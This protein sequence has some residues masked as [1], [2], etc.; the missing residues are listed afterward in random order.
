M[1]FLIVEDHP[2]TA[3]GLKMIIEEDFDNP[4][5]DIAH[6]GKE[7]LSLLKNNTYTVIV[8]DITLPDTDTQ[9]L[10]SNIK[11]ISEN[12]EIL[13]CSNSEPKLYAMSYISM[14]ASGYIHKSFSTQQLVTAIK[15]V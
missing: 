3:M 14:G 6:N 11:R 5:V 7:T 4:S 10:L 2:I 15:M 13:V 1:R 9:S 12:T 8:L